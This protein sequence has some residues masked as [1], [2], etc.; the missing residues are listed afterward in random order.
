LGLDSLKDI[1][2]KFGLPKIKLRFF[3]ARASL[4][5]GKALEVE[6][7]SQNK[8]IRVECI[9]KQSVDMGISTKNKFS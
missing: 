7:P 6:L 4:V 8:I 3:S 5:V 2:T 1:H 9:I